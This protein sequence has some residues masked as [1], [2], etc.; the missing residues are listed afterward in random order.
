MP[1]KTFPQLAIENGLLNEAQVEECREVLAQEVAAGKPRRP[2]EEV[3]VE[4]G[5]MTAEA[6]RAL[7]TALERL[8][9]DQNRTEP[10]KIGGYEIITTVGEGGLGTVYKARQ[11]SMGRLVALKV[12]H[13]KWLK[14]EEFK[15]RFL[16]EA[17]LAGRLSH[18]NLIQVFDVGRQGDTLYFSMEYI[19]GETVEEIVDRDGAMDVDRA[20]N[21]S[22]QVLR[23]ISYMKR[24]DIVHRDIKP[25]NIMLTKTGIAKLGDFGF[26]KSKFDALLAPD[27]EVLGT[28]DYI[29]PEQAM[30]TEEIDWRSDVYSLGCTLYHMLA[31]NPP[32]DGTGSTVMRKHIRAELPSPR[33]FN[34]E[35]PDAVCAVL[36]RMMAKDPDDR[37]G[38]MDELFEDLE[39]VKMGQDPKSPRLDAGRSTILRVY[40]IERQRRDRTETEVDRLRRHNL[41]MRM[42][43]GIMALVV[44]V[45]AVIIFFLFLKINY[46][47]G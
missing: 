33:E 21:I 36:E 9:R 29:S 1:P 13:K 24:F 47:A 32:F 46:T 34:P 11:I 40:R 8:A 41:W 44:V 26:V 31:G 3:I 39:M 43:V 12:L 37:Y 42:A 20:L 35:V 16:L 19:D 7:N 30:G 2:V 6:A 22:L 25:G 10:Q 4:R 14:D 5:Y 15:K 17:R 28:P 18:Q 23:A 45:L 38:N 27:G